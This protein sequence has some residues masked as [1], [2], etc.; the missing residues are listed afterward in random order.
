VP[1]L[2]LQYV[3]DA[4]ERIEPYLEPTPLIESAAL[5]AALK[6]ETVQ[7]TGAFKVR[8]AF[9]ALTR[10]RE[11]DAVVTASAGNHGLGIAYAA[12]TLEL[13]ATVVCAETASPAK[14]ELLRAFPIDLVL[15]GD[16]YDDAEA[17]AL[18]LA[19]GNERYVSAYNDPDVI[20]GSGTI[21]LELLD[22]IDGPFTVVTPLGGGG[23]TSGVAIA[24]TS[25]SGVRVIGVQS[26]AA[27]AFRVALDAGRPVR[28]ELLPS[29]ADG[30]SGNLD[31]GTITFDLVRRLVDD[32]VVVSEDDIEAGM[33]YLHREHAIVAEGA[34]AIGVGAVLAGRI[35]D[36]RPIVCVI[37][38]R[39]VADE[40][41]TR[42][43]ATA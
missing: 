31:P 13:R 10:L 30:L 9:A 16:T 3:V 37:S 36:D 39:N 7:P 42:V 15:Y 26:A 4:Q 41:L 35:P 22:E 27:P 29:L 34:G 40:T 32:V 2:E 24:A 1:A 28:I 12:E 25:R 23:L 19:A 38:G 43:L 11:G 8:G 5:G 17:H 14:L 33:R 21:G 20:A 18:A 6:L